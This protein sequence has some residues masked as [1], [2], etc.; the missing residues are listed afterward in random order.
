M[1][2]EEDSLTRKDR[3]HLEMAA[4][5]RNGTHELNPRRQRRTTR[6]IYKKASLNVRLGGTTR[7]LGGWSAVSS[8]LEIRIQAVPQRVEQ[9]TSEDGREDQPFEGKCG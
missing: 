9:Q 7:R 3:V 1:V 6:M 4:S 8:Q 5:V 2:Q